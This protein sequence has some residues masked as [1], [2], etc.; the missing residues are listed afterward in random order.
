[1]ADRFPL[2]VNETSRKIQEMVSGDNLDLSGNG[3]AIS[4]NT[5]VSGE[6]LRSTGSGLEWGTAGDVYTSTTQTIS[7]KIFQQSTFNGTVNTFTNIANESLVNSYIKINGVNISLGGSVATPDTNTTYSISALDGTGTEKII[8]LTAGGSGTGNDDI[9]IAAGDNVALARSGDTITI[10]SSFTDTDTVTRLQSASGGA[11]V[12]GDITI[13]AGSFTTVS[14]SGNTITIS[15]QD[16]NTVTQLRAEVGNT[17]LTGDVTFLGGDE[18]TLV[19]DVDAGTGAQTITVNSVDTIT[20]IKGGTDLGSELVSG[21]INLI[22]G[23]NV[24]LTQSTNNITITTA[25]DNTVTKI[26]SGTETLA[27]GDFRF[28][29]SG[30][31][32]LTQTTDAV[33]G[34]TT[35]NIE[36]ANDDTGAALGA[37]GGIVLN[38][39]NF[40]LKNNANLTGNYLTKWDADT[41]QLVDSIISDTGTNGTVTIHGSLE[42]TGTTTTVNSTTLNV[43]DPIIELRRGANLTGANGGIQVNRTTDADGVVTSYVQL[44]WNESGGFFRTFDGTIARR[45]VTETENQTLTNKILTSPTL[46]TPDIGAATATSVNGL[47]ITSTASSVLTLA[48]AKTLSVNNTLTFTGTDGI[49]IPFG[50]GP[51]GSSGVRVAYTSDSLGSFAETTSS[52]FRGIISDAVG[53]GSLIFNDN[54]IVKTGIRT[55]AAT[56]TFSL[57][58]TNALTINS[59]GAATAIVMGKLNDGTTTIQHGLDVK[60]NVE[61]CTDGTDTFTVN[62]QAGF[63]NKDI[64]LFSNEASPMRI[65]RGND[66]TEPSN[67]VIGVSALSGLSVSGSQ[68][69]LMG[70]EVGLG[71]SSAAENTAF[72]YQSLRGCFTGVDNVGVGHSTLSLIE[73]GDGNVAVGRDAG[74]ATVDGN[75][76]VFIGHWAGH[77]SQGSGNVFIGAAST[78]DTTSPTYMGPN[79]NGDNQLVIGSGTSAW[80]R[81]DNTF[82]VTIP[83]D[84]TVGGDTVIQGNLEVQ[85][86]TTSINSSTIEIDDK[87]IELAAAVYAQ[88]EGTA[89]SGSAQITNVNSVSGLIVGM[90][91]GQIGSIPVPGGAYIVGIGT[92]APYSVTLSANFAASGDGVFEATGPTDLGADGGGLIIKGSTDKTILYD[93]SRIKKYFTV[94]ESIDLAAGKEIAI[95]DQLILDSTTLGTSVVNSSLTSVGTLTGL[96]VTD[97]VVGGTGIAKIKA[98]IYEGCEND[99]TTSNAG[100]LTGTGWSIDCSGR[101][102]VLFTTTTSTFNQ[103]EFTGV[104]IGNSETYTLTLIIDSNAAATYVDACTVDGNPVTNGIYWSGGSPPISSPEIDILTFLFVKDSTGTLRVFGQGNTNF[105]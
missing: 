50:N 55:D 78:E 77:A 63:N 59:F 105:S 100:A 40:E 89:T 90:N 104:N 33:T 36:S 8:R 26:A 52:E 93:H 39:S 47:S 67:T 68:N 20:R 91:V 43:A 23:S 14:Q 1:M 80:I 16:T 29:Q 84:L 56:Q 82:K 61:L 60:D 38:G 27:A 45:L 4:G 13:A 70:Y 18:V 7:N 74:G 34:V 48:N 99:F 92:T 57:I 17:Y 30:A 44:A 25:N 6:Y 87:N 103:W 21:D 85:G 49:T 64:F 86:T 97:T 101:N 2:I 95:N 69:T 22:A 54:P 102:T 19:Q 10:S 71:M 37:A 96:E 28:T 62:G 35:I 58:N 3:I 5:G 94:S 32:T 66:P 98:K 46:T 83:N 41:N 31:T 81:G 9:K 12:S 73:D 24:T 42:V 72:G 51:G 75:Y 11:L 79:Q 15:G 65:G 53:T 88:F 76:N